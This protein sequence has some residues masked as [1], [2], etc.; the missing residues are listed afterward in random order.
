MHCSQQAHHVYTRRSLSHEPSCVGHKSKRK[1][2]SPDL[3]RKTIITLTASQRVVVE[4]TI[5]LLWFRGKKPPIK[6]AMVT[7]STQHVCMRRSLRRN[8]NCIGQWSKVST[9]FLYVILLSTGTY[10]QVFS[11]LYLITRKPQSEYHQRKKQKSKKANA[12]QVDIFR[13]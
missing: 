7:T 9:P 10:C 5:V 1:G 11:K 6:S 13:L 8:A 12:V 4:Q 3:L 2:H